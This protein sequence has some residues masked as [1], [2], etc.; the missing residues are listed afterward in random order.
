MAMPFLALAAPALALIGGLAA[1]CFV[2][3]YGIA[4][5]GQP[6]HADAAAIHESGWG[7]RLPMAVLAAICIVIGVFPAAVASILDAAVFAWKPELSHGAYRL[8][9]AAPL[10]W[11]TLLSGVLLC[12]VLLGTLWFI[13]RVGRRPRGV[14]PTWDCGYLQPAPRMQYTSSSFAEMLVKL[15][16]SVLRPH[17]TLPGIKGAFPS[18][19][20]F[21]SHVPETVLELIFLPFLE[22]AYARFRVIRR[23]Q[24]GQFHLYILY[25]FV[26]LVA[27]ILWAQYA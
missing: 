5:L 20:P 17:A 23:L 18:A 13:R 6:R 11:L 19:V 27:L 24:H 8:A 16:G 10:W 12:L 4:F 2:K 3:V 9:A 22:R 25:M 15:F 7:M 14:A 21:A 1:A 26:T